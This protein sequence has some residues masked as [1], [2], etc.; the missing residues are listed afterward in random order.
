M[1]KKKVKENHVLSTGTGT[2]IMFIPE[3]AKEGS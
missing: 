2:I 3:P 1:A